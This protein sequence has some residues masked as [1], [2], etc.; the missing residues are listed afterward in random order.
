MIHLE[1]PGC[2]ATFTVPGD[3]AGKTGKCPKCG[4][5]FTIPAADTPADSPAERPTPPPAVDPE[6]KAESESVEVQPCPGCQARIAVARDDLGT[7]VECPY[8]VTRFVAESAGSIPPLPRT[9]RR[10][11]P[12]SRRS[13]RRDETDD[14]FE[15]DT[16]RSRRRDSTRPDRPPNVATVGVMLLVGGIVAICWTVGTMFVT[17]AMTCGLCCLWPGFYLAPVWGV[18]AI[19]RG[20]SMVGGDDIRPTPPTVLHVLQIMLILN[21]DVVNL[22]LGIVGLVSTNSEETQDYYAGNAGRSDD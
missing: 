11:R 6:P 12:S 13:Q 8:C 4:T 20:S 17:A 10:E 22:V 2:A 5:Q 7:T 9:P 16:R 15:E 14:E 18:L 21:L 3:K 19:I 1:C